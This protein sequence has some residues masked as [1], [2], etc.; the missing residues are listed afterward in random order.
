M[1]KHLL[2]ILFFFLALTLPVSRLSANSGGHSHARTTTSTYFRVS[3]TH[4][5]GGHYQGTKSHASTSPH[6]V[7]GGHRSTYSTGVSRDSHGKIKRSS[8]ARY[9][10]MKQTGYPHGRP[11]YVIDHIIPL[12][13]G[14]SDSPSNMQWQTKQEAKE[15][16]KWE[17]K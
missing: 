7:S 17:R 8:S 4:K 12:S 5:P 15:K 2:P 9:E 16:D 14:G 10:F 13:K 1:K 6:H 11:G 3:G